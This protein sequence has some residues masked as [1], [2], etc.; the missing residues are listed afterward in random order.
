MLVIHFK[1]FPFFTL[2]GNETAVAEVWVKIDDYFPIVSFV[3]DEQF[4]LASGFC[5][6]SLYVCVCQCVRPIYVNVCV[7]VC[8]RVRATHIYNTMYVRM[9]VAQF[10]PRRKHSDTFFSFALSHSWRGIVISAELPSNHF[11]E[12]RFFFVQSC[13]I[14]REV[15]SIFLSGMS[16]FHTDRPSVF[17][18]PIHTWKLNPDSTQAYSRII[19]HVKSL[20]ALTAFRPS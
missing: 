19:W 17:K 1:M 14:E 20:L 13:R 12:R 3:F 9:C 4:Y 6:R 10:P 2:F 18:L 8:M 16:F 15:L 5:W 7:Y 11:I